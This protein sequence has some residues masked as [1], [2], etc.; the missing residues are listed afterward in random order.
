MPF[1]P[2]LEEPLSD[3]VVTLRA[4]AERDIPEVLIAYQDDPELHGALGEQ[5]PPSGAALGRRAER[6]EDDRLAGLAITL[7]ILESGSDLCRGEVRVD[8]VDWGSRTA[9]LR[10]WV[11]P[12]ARG[13]GLGRR[14]HELVREWLGERCHL[15]V[16]CVATAPPGP[17]G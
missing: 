13:Q 7:A 2:L 8:E 3:G 1:L 4:S 15:E 9:A 11:A 17:A 5:R 6:A 14:A 12:Q 16:R 10:V